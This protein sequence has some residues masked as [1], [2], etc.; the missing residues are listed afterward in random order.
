MKKTCAKSRLNQF[1]TDVL[2]LYPLKTPENHMDDFLK[3]G[4][5]ESET[6]ERS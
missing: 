1:L 2:I 5:A 4:V 6:T 3:M